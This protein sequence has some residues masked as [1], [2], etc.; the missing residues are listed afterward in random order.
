MISARILTGE[1]GQADWHRDQ[2]ESA[3]KTW[4]EGGGTG[5]SLRGAVEGRGGCYFS[6]SFWNEYQR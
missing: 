3:G 1:G 5:E 2:R 6:Y 4:G